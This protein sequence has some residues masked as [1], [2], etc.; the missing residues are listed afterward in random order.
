V[1]RLLLR[2][3]AAAVVVGLLGTLAAG[4]IGP[5][6]VRI[7]FG[8]KVDL[9]ATMLGALGAST[10]LL[11]LGLVLQPG[12]VALGRHRIVAGS[13]ALGGIALVGLVFLPGDPLR[14]AIIGQL[15]GSG[16]VVIGMVAG[17]FATLRDRPKPEEPPVVFLT[18]EQPR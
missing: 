18:A 8:A 10:M 9:G 5:W 14:A 6:A 3:V 7:L 11:M 12:L 16:L 15:V 17:L 4:G 1:R 13:W 2:I